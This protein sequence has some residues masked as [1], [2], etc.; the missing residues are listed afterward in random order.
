MKARAVADA[1]PVI[2]SMTPRSQVIRATV[3]TENEI[4]NQNEY[5]Y[6]YIYVR[7]AI[8]TEDDARIMDANRIEVVKKTCRCML[9][10]SWEKKNCSMTCDYRTIQLVTRLSLG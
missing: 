1:P 7:L 4:R 6:I 5:I 8:G 3:N 10:D 2:S 9:N